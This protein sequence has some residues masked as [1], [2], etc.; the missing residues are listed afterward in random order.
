MLK[1][2]QEMALVHLETP[3]RIEALLLCHFLALLAATENVRRRSARRH[4]WPVDHYAEAWG[5]P[6]G[7]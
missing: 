5:L 7:C 6:P 4:L 2:P 1:G 3:H